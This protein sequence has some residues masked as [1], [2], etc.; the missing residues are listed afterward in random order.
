MKTTARL[1]FLPF[2]FLLFDQR[3]ARL[4]LFFLSFL[5]W[6]RRAQDGSFV[7][8][9]V[10]VDWGRYCRFD[11]WFRRGYFWVEK[12]MVSCFSCSNKGFDSAGARLSIR[13]L[14]FLHSSS[15][16]EDNVLQPCSISTIIVFPFSIVCMSR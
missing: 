13:S 3:S 4:P 10:G 9:C 1:L 14:L 5:F 7:G 8:Y 15:C 6:S 2:F 12:E 16:Y 11:S